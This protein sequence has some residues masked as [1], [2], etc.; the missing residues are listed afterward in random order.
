MTNEPPVFTVVIADDDADVR[1]ALAGLL[2]EHHG[3]EVTGQAASGR[4][5][6]RLCEQLKPDLALVDV[7]MPQGGCDAAQAIRRVSPETAMVAY[8]ARGDR[9]TREQLIECGF[10]RVFVKG[11]GHD[12]C[13]D[14]YALASGPRGA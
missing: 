3:L 5:A 1:A 6:A 11:G 10:A 4:A 7:M 9:R 12:L 13:G 8:T 2:S 14:L